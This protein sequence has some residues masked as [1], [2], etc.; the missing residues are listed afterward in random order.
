MTRL[1]KED[2]SGQ[3]CSEFLMWSEENQ[4]LKSQ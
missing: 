2:T 4:V 1:G 3:Y